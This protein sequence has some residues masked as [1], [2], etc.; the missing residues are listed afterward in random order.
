[1]SELIRPSP[2]LARDLLA[3]IDQAKREARARS[4]RLSF[5]S[6]SEYRWRVS[7]EAL[8]MLQGYLQHHAE[9]GR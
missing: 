2:V 9:H 6:P 1:M 5:E 4:P 8:C 3:R 7:N